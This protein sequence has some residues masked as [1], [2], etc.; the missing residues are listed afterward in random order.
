VFKVVNTLSNLVSGAMESS[1]QIRFIQQ[2]IVRGFIDELLPTP[3]YW[4]GLEWFESFAAK[5]RS[6]AF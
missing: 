4:K 3:S 5:S 2:L 1:M 6:L